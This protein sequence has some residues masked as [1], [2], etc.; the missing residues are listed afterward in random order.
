[1]ENMKFRRNIM[2]TEWEHMYLRMQI[3]DLIEQKRDISVVKVLNSKYK[4][5]LNNI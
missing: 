1:M 4:V 5:C 2:A 3:N